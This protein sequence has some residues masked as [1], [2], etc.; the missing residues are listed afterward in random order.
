MLNTPRIDSRLAASLLALL[1]LLL[2]DPG[3]AAT[4]PAIRMKVVEEQTGSPVAGA[5]VLFL[6]TA[7]EGTLTGHGGRSANLFAVETMTDDAGEVRIPK[8]E[9]SSEPFFMNTIYDNPRLV[10]LKP[11]Y[12]LLTL[13]NTLRIIPN[14]DEV[15]TW[16]YNDQAVKIKRS[17]DHDIPDTVYLA[18]LYAGQTMSQKNVCGWKKAPRFFVA[19]DRMAAEWSQKRVTIADPAVRNKSV[20]SPLQ[21]ILTNEK[22]FAEK[23]CGSAKAFFEPYLR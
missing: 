19:V 15:T 5:N 10:V 20:S 22:F 18:S 23:G 16:Q 8:Q 1:A 6:G 9:F 11:G 13:T 17:T 14:L 21:M 3:S 4:M 7:H 2:P 12:A